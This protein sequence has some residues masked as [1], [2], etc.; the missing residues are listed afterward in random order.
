MGEYV[1]NS[2]MLAIPMGGDDVFVGVHGYNHWKWWLLIFMI[3]SLDGKEVE[4]KGITRKRS[5]AI[6]SNVMTNFLKMG[7]QGVIAQ[8]CSIDV[9][10]SKSCISLDIQRVLDKHFKV[11]EDIP[12]GIPPP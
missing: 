4:L 6:N 5:K 7:H 2:H 8:L 1:L 10:T 3:F 12:K 9:L 11:F